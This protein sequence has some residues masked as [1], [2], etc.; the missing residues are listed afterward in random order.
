MKKLLILTIGVFLVA[1]ATFGEK[2]NQQFFNNTHT[3]LQKVVK[4]GSVDYAAA[5][6]DA[7]LQ[8]LI[9]TI[10]AA[11]L[12]SASSATKQAFYINAYNLLVINSAAKA[13]PVESVMKI[14]GFFDSKKFTVEGQS[15]T[16]NQIEKEYLIK[17]YG[18]ARYHFVLVCGANGCPP[19]T[20]FAYTA[21]KLE[22]QLESQT[23]KALNDNSFIKVSE[24]N[25]SLSQIFN[26]YSKDF[27]T[28]KTAVVDFI[29]KYRKD[30]IQSSVNIDYYKYD[31][32]LNNTSSSSSINE[33]ERD[34]S[35]NSSRYII[36]S[37]IAK[38]AIETKIFNNL[39]TQRT[40]AGPQENLENRSTFFTTSLSFLYGLSD[41]VN[42]GF[43]TRYRRVRNDQLPSNVLSVFGNTVSSEESQRNGITSIGPQIRYAPIPKWEN[44]SIQS[45]FVFAL[46]EDLEGS[47]SQPYIDWSGST[48]W[49]QFFNDF[50][51]GN[52]FS[53]FT[54][55]D[56]LI[57]DIG[58]DD[59]NRLSTP[60][61][62]IFSYNPTSKVTL[63]TLGSYSPY[64]QSDFDYF[65]QAGLGAKY[66]FN[67]NLELELLYTGFTNKFLND[68]GGAAATYNVGFRF[69]L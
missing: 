59:L 53:L 10:A 51:I 54:E 50:S 65:A 62:L 38:G 66:Q 20:N 37:T 32:S 57:E 14:N 30:K 68:T 18:D 46:G 61:T 45:S 16:L 56:L 36:S 39:Y 6:N 4:N 31:W 27:G 1:T 55:V 43:S 17:T 9:K 64:W 60:V 34:D 13:Y 52:N 42:V 21:E 7:S 2:I 63:Y 28:S 58:K 12:S 25:V 41:R 15:V 3:F 40:G 23:K 69:N 24:N 8:A 47:N 44:F 35:N 48:W 26:W 33:D 49:T 67:S 29:N 22:Q 11:D 5:K 19:I